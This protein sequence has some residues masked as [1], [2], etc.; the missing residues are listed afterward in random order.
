MGNSL[1]ETLGAILSD[2]DTLR[3]LQAIAGS[4][5][6][7]PAQPAAPE[8]PAPAAPDLTQLKALS[9]LAGGTGID[10]NQ[11]ALLQALSP[12]LSQDRLNRLENAMRAAKMAKL[13]SSFLGS[14]GLQLLTGR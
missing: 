6:S 2:P 12:Y 10:A 7:A 8:P 5:A 13:A 9:S 4:L 14:G 3:Q 11:Q 1:E